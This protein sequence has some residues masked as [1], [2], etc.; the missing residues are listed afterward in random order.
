MT[1]QPH[2]RPEYV[3][4]SDSGGSPSHAEVGKD[5]AELLAQL[6][7]FIDSEISEETCQRFR[8]HIM[9]C[10][11][12]RDAVAA[13]NRLREVLRR[14]CLEVAPNQLR[15]RVVTQIGILRSGRQ[16]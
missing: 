4:P 10:D 5:C 7:E 9:E 16:H 6:F 8:N 15:L 11:S 2:G 13:E 3:G 14:S 1:G 12:C